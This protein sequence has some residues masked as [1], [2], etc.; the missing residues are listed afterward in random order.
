MNRADLFGNNNGLNR[1]A[2]NG[3]G[4]SKRDL[5]WE[6]KRVNKANGAPSNNGFNNVPPPNRQ[7]QWQKAQSFDSQY[8]TAPV[9]LKYM[10]I[11]FFFD[12]FHINIFYSLITY[13]DNLLKII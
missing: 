7:N 2:N 8:N 4:K 13:F 10:F 5:M 3:N 12:S 11:Y 9:N 6:Q 1:G